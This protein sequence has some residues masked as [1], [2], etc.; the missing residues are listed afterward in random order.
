[1]LEKI[2]AILE[3]P[4]IY[5]LANQ[6][7]APGH[8]KL[9]GAMHREVFEDSRGWVLDVG[10]GPKLITPMP[11]GRVVGI[12][13][14]PFYVKQ[15]AGSI[16]QDAGDIM[17]ITTQRRMFGVVG[18]CTRMP[19]ED[20]F[21]D[22]SRCLGVLHHLP[23]DEVSATIKEMWRCTK[24]G[25]RVILDEPVWPRNSFLRPAAW[26]LQLLDRG[27]WVRK[28]QEWLELC[29]RSVDVSWNLRRYTCAYFGQEE[30][31]IVGVKNNEN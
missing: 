30:I 19:F 4:W 31:I 10:C 14:N 9:M 8:Q 16:D 3:I 20:G 22:E 17:C 21:F 23:D 6:F 29:T 25:G 11:D 18:S 28:E 26:L 24:S 13:I 2:Y 27:K 5:S 15:Y 12:D 1:M 7:L